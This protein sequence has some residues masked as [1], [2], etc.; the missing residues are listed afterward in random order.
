MEQ[1]VDD[2]SWVSGGASGEMAFELI[3]KEEQGF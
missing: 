3:L 2:P 1:A